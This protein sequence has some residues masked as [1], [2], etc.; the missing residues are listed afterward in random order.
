[1][2]RWPRVDFRKEIGRDWFKAQNCIWKHVLCEGLLILWASALG[3]SKGLTAN[4]VMPV[5]PLLSVRWNDG[6]YEC[7]KPSAFNAPIV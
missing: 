4:A 3:G 6:L 2:Q 1:M 7:I 5:I